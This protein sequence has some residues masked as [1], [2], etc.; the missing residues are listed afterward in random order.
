MDSRKAQAE[1][2][3]KR[4]E[5]GWEQWIVTPEDTLTLDSI[6]L[7]LTVAELYEDTDLGM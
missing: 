7:D 5:G 1:L 4:A 6:M 3:R 2:Y